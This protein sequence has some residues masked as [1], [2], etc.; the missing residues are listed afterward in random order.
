MSWALGSDSPWDT[1]LPFPSECHRCHRR[2]LD[3]SNLLFLKRGASA[4]PTL[5]EQLLAPYFPLGC[6]QVRRL[7]A[8]T[9]LQE[10]FGLWITMGWCLG[11]AA[12]PRSVFTAHVAL[13]TE[14]QE[15]NT[16]SF[17]DSFHLM[18][19]KTGKHRISVNRISIFTNVQ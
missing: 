6:A 16:Y 10:V 3:G 13:E 5:W 14:M 15:S 4:K 11:T 8:A 7:R 9:G 2:H 12:Q 19:E 1:S 17:N 18:N